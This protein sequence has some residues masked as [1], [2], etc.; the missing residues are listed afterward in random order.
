MGSLSRCFLAS[1]LV[2]ERP[3]EIF[4]ISISLLVFSSYISQR[5]FTEILR[6][7]E[8]LLRC[9]QRARFIVVVSF[10]PGRVH[11]CESKGN[12]R[13]CNSHSIARKI[14]ESNGLKSDYSA[15]ACI[16]LFDVAIFI[17]FIYYFSFIVLFVSIIA[18]LHS[19]QCSLCISKIVTET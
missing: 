2:I 13:V 1:L 9:A 18:L 6:I 10:S 3:Q 19:L 16:G 4:T 14:C 17:Y 7:A 8:R 15:I 11:E 12:K 5:S